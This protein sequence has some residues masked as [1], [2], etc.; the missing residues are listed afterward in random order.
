MIIHRRLLMI[1]FSSF[2]LRDV[3]IRSD[4]KIKLFLRFDN[5]MERDEWA[6]SF[7]NHIDYSKMMNTPEELKLSS[8]EI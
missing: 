1:N 3:K 6:E 2:L 5:T 7:Q 4:R 8:H